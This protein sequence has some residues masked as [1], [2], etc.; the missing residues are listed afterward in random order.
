MTAEVATQAPITS[1]RCM[2]EGCRDEGGSLTG[3]EDGIVWCAALYGGVGDEY[4]IS[5]SSLSMTRGE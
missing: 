4:K 1:V 2:E 3:D 5:C